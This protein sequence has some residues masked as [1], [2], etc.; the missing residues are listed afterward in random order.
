[1]MQVA[2]R[3]LVDPSLPTTGYYGDKTAKAVEKFQ[4]TVGIEGGYEGTIAGPRTLSA[5]VM[6]CRMDKDELISK[7]TK[8]QGELDSKGAFF[9][10]DTSSSKPPKHAVAARETIGD[11]LKWLGLM[12]ADVSAASHQAQRSC[13]SSSIV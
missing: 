4:E 9:Y 11:A 10:Y 13:R 5:L 2:L 7:L 1:M 12:D 3:H 6:R 8:S